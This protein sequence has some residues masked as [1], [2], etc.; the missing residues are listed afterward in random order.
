MFDVSF[1]SLVL[2]ILQTYGPMFYKSIMTS[3]LIPFTKVTKPNVTYQIHD[4]N[5]SIWS[6]PWCPIWDSIHSHLLLPVTH[7]PLPGVVADL[8][9]PNTRTWNLDLLSNIFDSQAVQV[10]SQVQTVPSQD[11]DILRWTPARKG[12]CTTKNVYRFLS[13]QMQV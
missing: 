1:L 8:W 6:S 5:S 10:I 4:G 13:S 7:N 9:F 3:E 11:P 2:T 12:D